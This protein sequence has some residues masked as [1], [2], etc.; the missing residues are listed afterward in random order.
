[1]FSGLLQ[2]SFCGGDYCRSSCLAAAVQSATQRKTTR[3]QSYLEP[4]RGSL[5]KYRGGGSV[6]AIFTVNSMLK[7][8]TYLE[9]NRILIVNVC[10]KRGVGATRTAQ[11]TTVKGQ[12]CKPQSAKSL[13]HARNIQYL[14]DDVAV[15]ALGQTNFLV[16]D[17]GWFFILI[18][19]ITLLVYLDLRFLMF[20]DI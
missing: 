5:Q 9:P 15:P 12:T 20:P 11:N 8:R 10:R 2:L 14:G 1:M 7:T 17:F 18:S 19:S 6:F 16:L 13:F 4:N 3:R